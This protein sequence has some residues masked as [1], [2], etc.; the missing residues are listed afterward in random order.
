VRGTAINRAC[1]LNVLPTL[2]R[3]AVEAAAAIDF[4]FCVHP[5]TGRL[6]A[7]LAGGVPA[8]GLVGETG[9]GTGAG[10]AWMVSA[11][12]FARFLS[13]EKDDE[14]VAAARGVFADFQTSRLFMVMRA[15]FLIERRLTC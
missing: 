3:K 10:L 8:G 6:L 9:T 12:P 14:R 1:G 11:N 4:D 7:V 15:N 2:V 13:V 5:S